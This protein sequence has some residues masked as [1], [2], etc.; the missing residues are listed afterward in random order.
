MAV[1]LRCF[2]QAPTND[3]TFIQLLRSVTNPRPLRLCYSSPTPHGT[4]RRQALPVLAG[5][6]SPFVTTPRP[7]PFFDNGEW[8]IAEIFISFHRAMPPLP[9]SEAAFPPL[10]GRWLR[11]LLGPLSWRRWLRLVFVE[12]CAPALWIGSQ[13]HSFMAWGGRW[14]AVAQAPSHP[15]PSTV[16]CRFAPPTTA[17]PTLNRQ[18]LSR[19]RE[20]MKN[21]FPCKLA[22]VALIALRPT[23][24][25]QFLPA[26]SSEQ[27]KYT[28][29]KH[30]PAFRI[31]L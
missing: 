17:G 2:S 10:H 27:L 22:R 28:P 16:A 19:P 4:A 23:C 15:L 13:S 8:W 14:F 31:R 5:Q 30:H 7:A 26:K 20:M 11:G 1:W 12:S 24:R 21:Y 25:T 9:L 29:I 6:T 3:K 18:G